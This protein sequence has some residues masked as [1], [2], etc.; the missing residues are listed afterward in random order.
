[1]I[2]S[3]KVFMK[4]TQVYQP[5]CHLRIRRSVSPP[6]VKLWECAVL[7]RGGC[8][9]MV[10]AQESVTSGT[11]PRSARWFSESLP[12]AISETLSEPGPLREERLA[13]L[14]AFL[15]LPAEK[16]PLYK[17]Y[18]HLVNFDLSEVTPLVK[19]SSFPQPQAGKREIL[20]VHDAEGTH[21]HWP[22][23][24]RPAGVQVQT[25][26]DLLQS[27]ADT[28]S[29]FLGLGQPKEEKFSAMNLALATHWLRIVIPDA[30]ARPVRIREIS[31]L[32]GKGQ[33]LAVR[34]VLHAGRL[35]RVF[36]SEE[37]YTS[38]PETSSRL[39]SSSTSLVAGADS[40]IVSLTNHTPDGATVSFYNRFLSAH[41][42][43]H[44]YWLF[45]GMDGFRTTVRNFSR[46]EQQGS[47]VT[48]LQVFYGD[49]DQSC[50]SSIRVLHDADDTRGQSIS[51]GVFKDKARGIFTGMMR[52]DP[53]VKKIFSYLSEHAMLLSKSARAETAPGMEILSSNDVKAAHSSSVAP[54]DAEKVFYLESRGF[55]EGEALRTIVEGFLAS[56]L[57]K[58]PLEGI[59]Q[60]LYQL[61]DGRWGGHHPTWNGRGETESLLP[62]SAAW[63]EAADVR[64]DEKL[65]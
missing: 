51:R 63:K 35:S 9:T 39:Y 20:V 6:A 61:L 14:R 7:H 8:E 62:G 50:S 4:L 13:G 37:V 11:A 56:A 12:A 60:A 46:L 40:E 3:F 55:P 57:A 42:N 48:D 54:L 53:S 17:K 23:G 26:E 65:R 47:E 38:A 32:N 19:G 64:I 27:G 44:V 2:R 10:A 45:S 52:I 5:K 15:A 22:E 28:I 1:M 41:Q 30:P 34:R 24:P 16:D 18:A 36:H 58:S 49:E 29:Q 21:V 59:D 43:A 33:A 25:R 31:V